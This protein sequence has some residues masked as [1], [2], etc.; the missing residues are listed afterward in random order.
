[1][2]F[3]QG[4][5]PEGLVKNQTTINKVSNFCQKHTVGAKEVAI[6]GWPPQLMESKVI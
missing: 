6:R 2:Q 5:I 3:S 1:M 4:S